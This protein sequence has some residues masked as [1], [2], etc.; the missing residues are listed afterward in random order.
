MVQFGEGLQIFGMC[1]LAS[2]S[3]VGG[4][5]GLQIPAAS[6]PYL[7]ALLSDLPRCEQALSQ[8]PTDSD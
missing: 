3:G 8:A 1:G 2:K 6:V 4:D 7:S 5:G